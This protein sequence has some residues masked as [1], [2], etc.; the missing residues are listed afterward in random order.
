M[1]KL[2]AITIRNLKE[3]GSYGDGKGLIREFLMPAQSNYTQRRTLQ[4]S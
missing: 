1:T 4:R 2:T 3:P